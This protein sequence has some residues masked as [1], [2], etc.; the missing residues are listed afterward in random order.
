MAEN[1]KYAFVPIELKDYDTYGDDA[2]EI[3]ADL[4]GHMQD[5]I[6]KAHELIK[7]NMISEDGKAILDELIKKKQEQED[8]EEAERNRLKFTSF[9]VTYYTKDG[10]HYSGSFEVGTAVTK[11]EV[12]WSFNKTPTTLTFN[13]ETIDVNTTQFTV[14]GEF[15]SE[16]SWR[17]Q[18]T[19]E[20]GKQISNSA[21]ISFFSRTY[22][23]TSEKNLSPTL[24][25]EEILAL[26]QTDDGSFLSSF[27]VTAA[28]GEYIYYCL[29][30]SFGECEFSI[31]GWVG[32]F[33][34]LANGQFVNQSNGMTDYRIYRSEQSGLGNTTVNVFSK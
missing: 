23:G 8:A 2:T 15:R 21:Y 31:D 10:A 17:L 11:I 22:Y 27:T 5:G 25:R 6:V 34:E 32:G 28:E 13:G 7:T 9:N 14:N 30:S 1:N 12:T 33:I 26:N 24:N 16:Q 4:L 3:D 29:P 20:T 19:D 18:A